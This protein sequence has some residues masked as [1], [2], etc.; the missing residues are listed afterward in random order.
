MNLPGMDDEPSSTFTNMAT[1]FEKLNISVGDE[2]VDVGQPAPAAA[3]EVSWRDAERDEVRKALESPPPNVAEKETWREKPA[4]ETTELSYEE[5]AAMRRAQRE[6]KAKQAEER[7][8]KYKFN[9]ISIYT[10]QFTLIELLYRIFA[11]FCGQDCQSLRY[12]RHQNIYYILNFLCAMKD[13]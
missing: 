8:G 1:L 5:R 12:E 2:S 10:M 9:L 4:T 3:E 13:T 6:R 11:Q 7:F